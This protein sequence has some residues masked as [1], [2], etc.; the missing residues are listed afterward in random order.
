VIWIGYTTEYRD[1]GRQLAQAART[2]A[3]EFEAQGHRVA[4]RA[5]E[6][7]REFVDA[8]TGV[9]EP[10]DEL[11][12]IAHSG[13]Y[14]PMFG[15][16]AMPEQFSPH[17][18]RGLDLPLA[19]R[20]EAF[21]HSCRSGRWFAPFFARTFGVPASGHHWYTTVSR[22]PDRYRWVSPRL[23]PDA[24]MYV[25][26]QPGRKSHGMLGAVGKHTG[27][28]PPVPM[29]RY[30]PSA[31]LPSPAYDRVA[32]LYDTTFADIR[33]RGPEWSWIDSHVP[34]GARVLDLGCG[35]GGLLRAL[36]SRIGPGAGADVSEAMLAHARRRNPS[37]D[38][39][40]VEGP[41]L[42]FATDAF[43]VVVSLLSW[44]YLDWDPVLAEIARVLRPGGRLLVVDMVAKPAGASE[45]PVVLAHKA[46]AVRNGRRFPGYGAARQ[47][48]VSDPG[49]SEMLRYNPIRAV[50]E[51]RWF[52]E[53]RFPGRRLEV[54][55][56]ARRTRIVAFDSGP[57][58]GAWFPPQSYP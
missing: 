13:M 56:V 29:V 25:V 58:D 2:L 11:H 22:S 48:L 20:A 6:T 1:G 34:D 12:L 53:S 37:F 49:W 41:T 18:W 57:I 55:D 42:P 52:F 47:R 43:D 23:P 39:R 45:V 40:R 26:G 4:C 17:E 8:V 30:E 19:P 33:V 44:R 54:L 51:Y 10:I 32:A 7:K 9:P 28:L 5:V 24:P 38:W 21:F 27:R 14:G 46:R 31:G 50:H 15:A 36:E 16:T 35:T 3:R